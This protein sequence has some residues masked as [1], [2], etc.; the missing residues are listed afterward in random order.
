MEGI[1]NIE[2]PFH[3][4][5]FFP[6]IVKDQGQSKDHEE[7]DARVRLAELIGAEKEVCRRQSAR[8]VPQE[9]HGHPEEDEG[10]AVFVDGQ[11]GEKAGEDVSAEA[12]EGGHM[13]Y[14]KIGDLQG[15]NAARHPK[16]LFAVVLGGFDGADDQTGEEHGD[17]DVV[18]AEAR[19]GGKGGVYPQGEEGHEHPGQIE[20]QQV[21]FSAAG[22]GVALGEAE[23]EQGVSPSAEGPQEE[24]Q[25][26]GGEGRDQII[27][28]MVQQHQ[29]QSGE[30][31]GKGTH[32]EAAFLFVLA[33]L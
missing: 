22:M 28:D 6:V 17:K 32:K 8:L 12:A 24:V 3:S 30:F 10:D 23:K 18:V 19:F 14:D 7:L 15:E 9:V 33:L 5:A 25:P 26:R 13:A 20:P 27:T 1:E 16:A 31:Q 2:K 4:R 21:F 29:D 11:I